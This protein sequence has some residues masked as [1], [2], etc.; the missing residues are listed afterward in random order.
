MKPI[1][2]EMRINVDLD[3]E[4][5][6][7]PP[8]GKENRSRIVIRQTNEVGFQALEA[9]MRGQAD[10]DNACLE[11]INFLDHLFRESPRL[12]YTQIKRSFFAR[13]EQRFPLGGGVEAFKG[14]YQSPR[15][16]SGPSGAQLTLNLDVMNG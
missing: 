15:L 4:S 10:F 1:D 3:Q 16:C 9:Y 8:P 7:T 5:G 11:T 14:V 13:G 12:K 6:K 2:R